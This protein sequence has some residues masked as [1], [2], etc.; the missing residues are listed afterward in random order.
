MVK[1]VKVRVERMIREV[2]EDI[3]KKYALLL[4]HA[5][6]NE[7]IKGKTRFMK[8]LFLISKNITELEEETDFESDNYGPNSIYVANALDDLEVL[9]LINKID[10]AYVLTDLGKGIVNIVIKDI[11]KNKIEVIDDMKELCN[12]LSTDELLALV[13]YTYPE[14]TD[15][16]LVKA[17]I[18]NKREALALS[19]LKKGKVSIGKA[20]EIAGLPMSS[21]YNLLKTKKIKIKMGAS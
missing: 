9:N 18:E 10:N 1:K 7:P 15:E 2:G 16:S 5:I 20:S 4:L 13:Y 21:L 19:L 12:N 17:R 8:E 11:A 3:I 14:I 6:D